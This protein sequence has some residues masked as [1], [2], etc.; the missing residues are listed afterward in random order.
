MSFKIG[1]ND[2]LFVISGILNNFSAAVIQKNI[3]I[4]TGS[5]VFCFPVSGRSK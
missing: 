2:D 5:V 4:I 1:W 3:G